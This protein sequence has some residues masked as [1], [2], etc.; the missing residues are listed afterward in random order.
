MAEVDGSIEAA[1]LRISQMMQV[2][3]TAVCLYPHAPPFII[4][5]CYFKSTKLFIGIDPVAEPKFPLIG[6]LLGPKGSFVKHI[7]GETQCKVQL[8]GKGSGFLE[9]P[10]QKGLKAIQYMHIFIVI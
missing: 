8:K 7:A 1:T 10:A 5:Y 6:K 4:N 3:T 9:S 2:G